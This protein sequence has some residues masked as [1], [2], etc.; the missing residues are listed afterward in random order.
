MSPPLVNKKVTLTGRKAVSLTLI[1]SLVCSALFIAGYAYCQ[2]GLGNKNYPTASNNGGPSVAYDYLVFTSENAS[3]TFHAAKASFGRMIDSCTSTNGADVL[4][5][6]QNAITS[7]SI[8]L[9]NG[10]V[11]NRSTT[12]AAKSNVN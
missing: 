7:G 2:A 3:G 4:S 6:C 5:S 1:V 12:S 9:Q 11:I 10:L 8:A